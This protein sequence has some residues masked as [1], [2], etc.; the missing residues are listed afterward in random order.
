[1][2]AACRRFRASFEPAA[3]GPAAL[4][5][6][7]TCP[8]C[9]AFACVVETARTGGARL[10]LPAGLEGRL[11]GLATPT[12]SPIPALP[13]LPLPL[14]SLPLPE[15]LAASL[16]AIGQAGALPASK[17]RRPPLPVWLRSPA[18]S[19]AASLAAAVLCGALWGDPVAA[20]QPLAEEV[21]QR[22]TQ[23]EARGR[24]GVVHGLVLPARE[25][26][27]RTLNRSR[28]FLA[29]LGESLVELRAEVR[30]GGTLTTT[31]SD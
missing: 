3:G 19:L 27:D 12:A 2:N 28:Q 25:T 6:R 14:V 13:D 21:E 18:A 4:T 29:S 9:D 26:L 7:A 16:R 20:A 31:H 22:L 10:P 1:M 11:R 23:V 5:H 24:E 17:A 15:G 8:A 30:G